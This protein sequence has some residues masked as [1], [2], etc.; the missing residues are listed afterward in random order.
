[1]ISIVNDLLFFIAI[2][3]VY[4]VDSPCNCARLSGHVVH[5]ETPISPPVGAYR[6]R[7]PAD[8]DRQGQVK[9]VSELQ[10]LNLQL[11]PT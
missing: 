10:R 8:K 9:S 1:M 5:H 4:P 2:F 11:R 3:I 6:C 7:L